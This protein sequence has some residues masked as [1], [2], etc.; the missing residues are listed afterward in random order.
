MLFLLENLKFLARATHLRSFGNPAVPVAILRRAKQGD[1][2]P[3]Y[4]LAKNEASCLCSPRQ[5]QQILLAAGSARLSSVSQ[6]RTSPSS[7]ARARSATCSSNTAKSPRFSD[8]LQGEE[9]A[10]IPKQIPARSN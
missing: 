3:G 10:I 9:G 8:S 5:V 1:N 2:P 6:P 4:M 7:V